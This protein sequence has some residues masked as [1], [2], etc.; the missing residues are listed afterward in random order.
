MTKKIMAIVICAAF[1]SVA[2]LAH[3]EGVYATENGKKYHKEECPLIKNKKPQEIS[4]K[5]AL[6][7]G[8]EPCGK[9]FKDEA[10]LKSGEGVKKVSSKRKTK[11]TANP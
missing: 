5:D 4:M 2:S 8:L 10:S 1:L 9:C 6:S 7:K 3:A 11:E